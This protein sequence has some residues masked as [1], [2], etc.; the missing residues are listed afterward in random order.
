MHSIL[1]FGGNKKDR[2]QKIDHIS[3]IPNFANHPDIKII[4]PQPGKSIGINDVREIEK[5][6]RTRPLKLTG[7]QVLIYSAENLTI[8]AQNALLKTL[9]EPPPNSKIILETRNEESLL[10]TIIS[11][12]QKINLGN[13]NT[14]NENTPEHNEQ[15][16]LFM[17]VLEKG[18]GEG[19]DFVESNKQKIANRDYAISLLD[20]WVSVLRDKMLINTDKNPNILNKQNRE[21]LEKLEMDTIRIV[22]W[23]EFS[24]KLRE[25]IQQT[26]ASSR[27]ALEL[28]LLHS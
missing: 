21:S 13:K 16:K 15:V 9:E 24:S 17:R 11:R 8:Q 4:K 1:I 3:A 5:F 10:P 7:K 12:C 26:N 2:E 19:L 27:L 18:R 25:T 6:L 20:I 22:E 28:F 23:V 14:V